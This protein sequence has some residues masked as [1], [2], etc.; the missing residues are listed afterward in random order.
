MSP[1]F[2]LWLGL[3]AFYMIVTGRAETLITRLGDIF[4]KKD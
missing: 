4:R 1:I 2:V 3:L